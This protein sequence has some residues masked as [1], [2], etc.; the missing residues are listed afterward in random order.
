M[1]FFHNPNSQNSRRVAVTLAIT[2]VEAET[3]LVNLATGEQNQPEFLVLN[4]NHK[5]PTLVDGDLKLWESSAIM[6]YVAGVAGR[7]DL[8]PVEAAAQADVSRWMVWNHTSLSPHCSALFFER[9]LKSLFGMGE[10]SEVEVEKATRSF[11]SAAAVLDAHLAE[12]E[13]LAQGR[14][15]L[16]DIAVG[17]SL[18]YAEAA[19]L[20]MAD[21]P[22]LA[23]WRGR[24]EA[25]PE[26]MANLPPRG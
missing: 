3:T 10:A 22:H 19:Q 5:V 2:G 11:K 21:Y 8:W 18:T 6:Q 17:C 24:I 7:T 15:T 13:Y 16:A 25:L 14:L 26:M 9:V 1:R 20:P 4:P 23:A 12:R